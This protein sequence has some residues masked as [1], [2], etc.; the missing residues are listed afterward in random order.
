MIANILLYG[1]FV[2]LVYVSYLDITTLRI[3]NPL[4]V[5]IAGLFVPFAIAAHMPLP[6]L[7]M[8]VAAGFAML[9]SGF[10]LFSVGLGFGGGDAKFFAALSLWCGFGDLLPLFVVMC[11]VGGA[12]ALLVFALRQFGIPAWLGA[13]GWHVSALN[14]DAKQSFVPYAPAMA[15][16]FI[17]VNLSGLPV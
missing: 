6:D 2:L 5:A 11:F 17:Y 3:P 16:A 1:L 4:V 15:L 7:V 8:H 10:V 13:H 9:V 12:M 14:K